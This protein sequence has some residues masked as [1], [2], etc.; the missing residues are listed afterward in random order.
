MNP[1]PAHPEPPTSNSKTSGPHTGDPSQVEQRGQANR[2]IIAANPYSGT[3]PNRKHVDRFTQALSDRGLSPQV[4]WTPGERSEV[5]ARTGD[6]A[7]QY[8]CRC[9]VAAGGDGSLA[10]LINDIDNSQSGGQNGGHAH[11]QHNIPLAQLPIGNENLFAREFGYKLRDQGLVDAIVANRSRPID[12]GRVN[13]KLF[14]LMVSFGFDAEVVHRMDRWRASETG[15]GVNKRVRKMT[16]VPKVLGS[17]CDYQFPKMT[18]TI[19]GE[20]HEAGQLFVFNIGQYG[21]NLPLARDA[22]PTDAKL[23]YV[24]FKSESR[25]AFAGHA[26]NVLLNRHQYAKDARIGRA[27]SIQVSSEVPVPM[28]AD[29]DGCGFTPAAVE[30]VANG[31]RIMD[32]APAA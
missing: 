31:V 8:D 3:G 32:V 30:V 25:I 20:P 21:G 4:L 24:L 23:D 11:E 27:S 7:W 10:D 29:G 28:Q 26:L 12:L 2:V 5:F 22:D 16:Y 13:G 17:L 14:T 19:D 1:T 9:V 15:Q 18:V 6:E